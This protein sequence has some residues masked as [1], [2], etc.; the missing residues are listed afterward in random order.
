MDLISIMTNVDQLP[1]D[2]KYRLVIVAAQRARQIMRGAR[3][4][5]GSRFA[6][7]TTIGLWEVTLSRVEY[8]VGK[9]AR[10]A[11]KEARSLREPAQP[12][13]LPAPRPD[14]DGAELKKDLS[15]F[16]AERQAAANPPSRSE[17]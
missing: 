1:I 12:R 2:S 15:I 14:E 6:K 4:E 8:L 16:L 17:E 11:M 13:V 5:P 10:A 3:P 7:E 9:D